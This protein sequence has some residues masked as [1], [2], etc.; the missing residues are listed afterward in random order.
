VG[1]G[2][3][4]AN[5]TLIILEY[6]SSDD[7]ISCEQKWIDLIKPEYNLNPRAGS[8]KGYKHTP[9]SLE[10]LKSR[11]ITEGTL[12]KMRA[13]KHSDYTK[14]LIGASSMGRKHTEETKA[15]ISENK[16]MKVTA[17]NL[18]TGVTQESH[19]LRALAKELGVPF[20]TLQRYVKNGKDYKG[21]SITVYSDI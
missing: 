19:S 4:F 1:R 2:E 16:G 17:L 18:E 12:A 14:A 6:S 10:K 20:T 13:R 7:V 3:G 15:K 11:I 9:E 21:Y 8:S 5:F